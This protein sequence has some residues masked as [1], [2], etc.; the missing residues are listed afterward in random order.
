[1]SDLGLKEGEFGAPNHPRMRVVCPGSLLLPIP[2]RWLC[3]CCLGRAVAAA[4][5]S[6][7][8][9]V[10]GRVMGMAVAWGGALWGLCRGE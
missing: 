7:L 9:W 1:M 4:C 3:R 6:S 2:Q 10:Q 8:I 5:P